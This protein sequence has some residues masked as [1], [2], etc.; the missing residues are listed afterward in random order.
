MAVG[1]RPGEPVRN[2]TAAMK[3][4][5]KRWEGSKIPWKSQRNDSNGGSGDGRNWPGKISW[6]PKIDS[7]WGNFWIMSPR[8][9][10][11]PITQGRWVNQSASAALA[12]MASFKQQWKRWTSPLD[13]GW[14]AVV[15][16]CEMEKM[17][18][19]LAHRTLAPCSWWWCRG[20]QTSG[21]SPEGGQLR[22]HWPWWRRAGQ[23]RANLSSSLSMTVNRYKINVDVREVNPFGSA[24]RSESKQRQNTTPSTALYLVASLWG[25]G[26]GRGMSPWNHFSL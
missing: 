15:W 14:Y 21:S 10:Y 2:E 11:T 5:T 1:H 23:L 26:V 17:E 22:S 3:G 6:K 13:W 16:L 4:S 12:R 20:R 18:Q 24:S 8:W 7:G 25:R 19:R 9:P